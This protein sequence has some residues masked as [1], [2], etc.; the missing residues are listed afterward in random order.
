MAMASIVAADEPREPYKNASLIW[1]A[2]NSTCFDRNMPLSEKMESASR[3]VVGGDIYEPEAVDHPSPTA[4]EMKET[5]ETPHV[6]VF[7][8]VISPAGKTELVV[9][10]RGGYPKMEQLAGEYFAKWTWKPAPEGADSECV[11]YILTHRICY[12]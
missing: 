6:L 5:N 3:F 1:E 10:L 7:E 9:S 2:E 4:E 11:R 12:Q 8:L